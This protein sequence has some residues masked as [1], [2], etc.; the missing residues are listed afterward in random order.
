MVFLFVFL[1]NKQYS[2]GNRE[3]SRLGRSQN[4][5][6]LSPSTLIATNMHIE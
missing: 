5:P 2:V 4:G 3:M 6:Y 1:F